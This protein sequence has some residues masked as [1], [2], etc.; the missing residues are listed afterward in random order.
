M[1]DI[2]DTISTTST[3]TDI[4]DTVEPEAKTTKEAM[5]LVERFG[6][7]I[8]NTLPEISKEAVY[9]IGGGKI[10]S[11]PAAFMLSRKAKER[12]IDLGVWKAH[13]LIK[14]GALNKLG[15]KIPEFNIPSPATTGE[16]V[17]DVAAGITKFVAELY[18]LKKV[19]PGVSEKALWEVQNLLS[20]GNPGEGAAMHTVFGLPGKVIK[21][22]TIAAKAGR[23]AAESALMGTTSVAEQQITEGKVNWEDVAISAGIA[24]ALHTAGFL[25][26]GLRLGN[27]KITTALAKYSGVPI[28]EIP[29]Y[30][31][32]GQPIPPVGEVR[33]VLSPGP[34]RL[35]L[36][37]GT[38]KALP[39]GLKRGIAG[40]GGRLQ[41][42]MSDAEAIDRKAQELYARYLVEGKE[43]ESKL[44]NFIQGQNLPT[45]ESL[46]TRVS[47]GDSIAAQMIH[48]GVYSSSPE[49]YL[50]GLRTEAAKQLGL[51]YDVAKLRTRFKYINDNVTQINTTR[52]NPNIVPPP[53]A[54]VFATRE[55][56]LIFDES[57]LTVRKTDRRSETF[58]FAYESELYDPKTGEGV[59][60]QHERTR[61]NTESEAAYIERVYGQS[62]KQVIEAD[63]LQQAPEFKGPYPYR[64]P[65]GGLMTEAEPGIEV[66]KEPGVSNL[67]GG[68]T[69]KEPPK[70]KQEERPEWMQPKVVESKEVG[71]KTRA[72]QG[73][74]IGE[75]PTATVE[76]LNRRLL[77]WVK[78]VKLKPK[79]EQEEELNKLRR[80]QAGGGTS[81]LLRSLKEGKGVGESLRAAK[82]AYKHK[83]GLIEVEPPDFTNAE[84]N[85]YSKRIL[86]I[87]PPK[88]ASQ[89]FQRTRTQDAL[90]KIRNGF[91]PTNSEF[92]LLE[93]I[94]G[95]KVTREIYDGL[96]KQRKYSWASLPGDVVQFFK[97]KFNW[98]VQTARQGRSLALRHPIVYIKSV[99]DNVHAMRSSKWADQ[100][101]ENMLNSPNFTLSEK[102][103]NYVADTGY[104]K[105][106][107]E[108][109]GTGLTE[110]LVFSKHKYLRGLGAAMKVSERGATVGIN[111]MLNRL[112]NISEKTLYSKL[113]EATKKGT[114][115][116]QEQVHKYRLNR[117][118]TIN[119][120]MKILRSKNPKIQ[121]LQRAVTF[122]IYSPSM[123]M[124]RPLSIK[125]MVA[126]PGSRLYAGE[127][128]AS[129]IASIFLLSAIPRAIG[130]V[131]FQRNPD[132]EPEI[133]G[134]L[135]PVDGSFGKIRVKNEAFDTS[136]GDAGFYRTLAR[137]GISAY[138]YSK[139]LATDKEQSTF[140]GKKVPST[141]STLEQFII[142]RE[143][144][145]L[146]WAKAVIT[147]RDWLGQPMGRLESTL[148]AITPQ[149]AETMFEAGMADGLWAGMAT[150]VAAEASI[151]TST[152]PV[153]AFTTRS[154]FE[155]EIAK[156]EYSLI[157]DDL[158]PIQQTHLKIK[159]KDSFGTLESKIRVEQI[160]RPWN[161]QS[162]IDEEKKAGDYIRHR[163]DVKVKSTLSSISIN[164]SRSPQDFYLNDERYQKY[165]D[166][167]VKY[168]NEFVPKVKPQSTVPKEVYQT[169]LESHVTM[170][171]ALALR[172]LQKEMQ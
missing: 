112:W 42:P 143:T 90:D 55:G 15:E 123:T 97:W 31:E 145:A 25:K 63:F 27:P 141:A 13:A 78:E 159:Y 17:T 103:I 41:L 101:I 28:S 170:A 5:G 147:G 144:A 127:I 164:V 148:R 14:G 65:G 44:T 21:G 39:S 24:P 88:D 72:V 151:G 29:L 98:D 91:I 110:R 69:M 121:E 111:S 37:G 54:N 61:G 167:V 57:Q 67:P 22:T 146:G 87:Y 136:M 131:L 163:L 75:P 94:F 114:P 104:S 32:P 108:Y 157:W 59:T 165:K 79:K 140:M 128:I 68:G 160:K 30:G 96:A 26:A 71:T 80:K 133:N 172:D 2:F 60:L 135:N 81:V 33:R 64:L 20:G 113:A 85:T 158:T 156:R 92:G 34:E 162:I 36:P 129:N 40:K 118:K 52:R 51:S 56:R 134:G 122:V 116:T 154:N 86:E 107:L 125:A 73:E 7:Q 49:S 142:S 48:E 169:I 6:K 11:W 50:E 166:L 12:G 139:E 74:V 95:R 53:Q 84:W 35:A 120:F 117:G 149:V 100:T 109:Y 124:A 9:G 89:Q 66:S 77:N 161:P 152:Y 76:S 1:V 18:A 130:H 38:Q 43:G 58:P 83:M 82:A 99:M 105:K 8:A 106:R 10:M 119:T 19:V 115:W 126:N 171:K 47:E 102:Y 155:N 150:A 138:L 45:L 168:L 93:S 153:P 16:K 137:L 23:I 70:S 46:Y 4:F 3:Q 62:E 132:K